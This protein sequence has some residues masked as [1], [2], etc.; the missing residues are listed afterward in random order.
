MFLY[1]LSLL[2]F[3]LQNPLDQA[4]SLYQEKKHD[5]TI[6]V[7]D[8]IPESSY[9]K[10]NLKANVYYDQSKYDSAIRY[11]HLALDHID[12]VQAKDRVNTLNQL[13][14]AYEKIGKFDQSLEV[15]FEALRIQEAGDSTLSREENLILLSRIQ[16]TIGTVLDAMGQSQ[17]AVGYYHQVIAI[18]KELKD[19]LG[20]TRTYNNLGII[21][22]NRSLYDSA[23]SYYQLANE[24]LP[25]TSNP[26][27]IH[28]QL[29]TNIGNVHKRMAHYDSAEHYYA[30]AIDLAQTLNR[31]TL[32]SDSYYNMASYWHDRK[33]YPR[34]ETEFL[35][36]LEISSKT[37]N[38]LELYYI[39]GAMSELYAA[40]GK[41]DLAY[42]QLL[43]TNE[44]RDILFQEEKE[45]AIAETLTKYETEK[46]EQQ[47]ALQNA[48]IAQHQAQNQRNLIIILALASVVL[49]LI[50]LAWSVKNQAKK[51][52]AILLHEAQIRLQEVEIAATIH[53]QEKER[54]RFA[55]DLHD[56]FGQ[57]ISIL[58]LHVKSLRSGQDPL[59]V[60]ENSSKIL[61]S[62]YD[63]LKS[64]CFNLM[65]QT[66]V[67]FGLKPALQEFVERINYSGKIQIE[68]Q[69][70]GIERRLEDIQEISLY[71]ISQEWI[72]N[73]IK[74]SD[75]TH[76]VI[77]LSKDDE[78]LL[79]SIEDDGSGF[80]PEKLKNSS[81]NGWR[82]MNARARILKGNI[83][84]VTA[85]GIPGTRFTLNA[86]LA[87]MMSPVLA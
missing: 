31:P 53:S 58:M 56:G 30:R 83:K 55:Q 47:I 75:A 65:P 20:I 51:K 34:S 72:N 42:E 18:R 49:L 66:L 2:F 7:L 32:L 27:A 21:Y 35:K 14:Q 48:E 33:K 86:K 61:D 11:L 70:T 28:W 81:G 39:H 3:T 76:V 50:A 87:E 73:I 54:S 4:K 40:W 60:S 59:A 12:E 80:D 1:L 62:M 23:L 26:Q 45:K 8:A 63:E 29:A 85:P 38:E 64:I 84:I 25:R 82:N 6:L 36:A 71:R 57:L 37:E 67:R 10:Y 74:Y 77:Q 46:K 17:K 15:L 5:S 43:K 9:G 44:Y 16:L 79:L 13:G 24:F 52:Q 22:K 41:K 19:S 69:F 78:K 68:T